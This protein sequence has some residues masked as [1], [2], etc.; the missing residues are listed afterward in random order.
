[1]SAAYLVRRF[2]FALLM[3]FGLLACSRAQAELAY[4]EYGP[5]PGEIKIASPR[6]EP[7]LLYRRP[8]TLTPDDGRGFPRL[9]T[10]TSSEAGAIFFASGLDSRIYQLAGG[11]ERLLFDAGDV[12]KRPPQIRT[13]RSVPG[14][15]YLYFSVVPTPQNSDPLSDGTI[16]ALNLRSKQIDYSIPVA[17]TT[18]GHDWWGAFLPETGAGGGFFLAS[19][20]DM[21]YLPRDRSEMRHFYRSA[22]SIVAL[23]K[24]RDA[25]GTSY[26]L[27]ATSDGAVRELDRKSLKQRPVMYLP[28]KDLADVAVLAGRRPAHPAPPI[29]G[30]F[31][32]RP[33][34]PSRPTPSAPPIRYPEPDFRPTATP[35]LAASPA[36]PTRGVPAPAAASKSAIAGR[37][38]AP[39]TT[40]YGQAE[41]LDASGRR[42]GQK[43]VDGSGRFGFAGLAPGQYTVVLVRPA[44]EFYRTVVPSRLTVDLSAGQ[45]RSVEFRLK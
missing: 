35:V 10:L 25:D 7:R 17:Q 9:C 45:L 8:L 2:A 34:R 42:V 13:V 43:R 28:T 5:W 29:T 32:E 19:R 1:M 36:V 23:I 24:Q 41:L 15:P 3:L 26:L 21:Y 6:A 22:Q 31:V 40:H 14:N 37:V 39:G 11:R 44:D 33:V 4:A 38:V 18:V 30:E 16:Y 27:Y 12:E 20:G